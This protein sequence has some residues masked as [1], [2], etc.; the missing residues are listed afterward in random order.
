MR[1][2]SE[3][4]DCLEASLAMYADRNALVASVSDTRIAHKILSKIMMYR[5][6]SKINKLCESRACSRCAAHHL[7]KIIL[8]VKEN[9]PVTFLLPSFPGKSPNP[10]KVLG[11]LP[12]YAEK[13]AIAFLQRL[14][15]EIKQFYQPGIKIILCSD[16]RVFSDVV[17][18]QEKHITAYKAELKRLIH[19]FNL[20]DLSIISLDDFY[21]RLS[22]SEMRSKMMKDYSESL[23]AIKSKI[24]RGA[25]ANASDEARQAN[26]LY[27]G[28]TRFLYEDSVYSEQEKSNSALQKEARINAYEVIR[29]SN[30]WSNLI[31]KMYPLAVRLS[32]HP[33]SCGSKKLGIRLVE[34]ENWMTPWHGVAVDKD[35]GYVLM[36]RSEAHAMGADLVYDENGRPSHY[37]Y[38]KRKI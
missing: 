17:G 6:I 1:K 21:R 33:Q 24:R 25:K 38:R 9:Q 10:E 26:I 7:N 36:K 3:K 18:M 27:R 28:I 30:A 20:V 2:I 29:R 34:N 14:C 13:L 31:E 8:A 4:I 11:Y 32:I 19:T 23:E 15:L 35:D 22:F 37:H 12:D 5:R 16:G